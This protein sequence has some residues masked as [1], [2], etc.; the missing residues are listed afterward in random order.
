MLCSM[1]FL[2]SGSAQTNW[3]SFGNDPGSMRYSP[4][5]QINTKNVDQLKVAWKFDTQVA[6]PAPSAALTPL[7]PAADDVI[8]A[9]AADA[10][11]QGAAPQGARPPG[12]GGPAG[13]ARPARNPN[14]ARG[15]ESIPLVVNGVL[16]VSTGYRQVL[17]LNAETGEKIWAYDSPHAPASR[18]VSYWAGTTGYPPEIVYGTPDGFLVALDAKTGKPAPTFGSGG[19]VDLK[20][21]VIPEKFPNARESA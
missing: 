4:L 10:Q 5:D 16:Y 18:G 9:P 19:T 20:V 13:A 11:P 2:A 14:A 6:N 8:H 3:P 17:A 1:A 12:A 7:V 15:S 21:G